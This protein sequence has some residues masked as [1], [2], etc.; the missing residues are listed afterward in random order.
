MTRIIYLLS[1]DIK[2]KETKVGIICN[3][4]TVKNIK[5]LG[6]ADAPKF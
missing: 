3:F 4:C 1:P 6:D 5:L 2:K